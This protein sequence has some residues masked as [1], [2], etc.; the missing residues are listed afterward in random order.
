MAISGKQFIRVIATALGIMCM[1][2][3]LIAIG[4][5]SWL[6]MGP[7]KLS[8]LTPYLERSTTTD[9][10]QVAIGE[11]WIAWQGFDSPLLVKLDDVNVNA[12][13]QQHTLALAELNVSFSWWDIV[14][15]KITPSTLYLEDMSLALVMQPDGQITLA[16]AETHETSALPVP[17]Q[18]ATTSDDSAET[19]LVAGAFPEYLRSIIIEGATIIV[20]KSD[21]TPLAKLTQARLEII[22][23][24][25]ILAAFTGQLMQ[26]QSRA[27]VK[28]RVRYIP[29]LQQIEGEVTFKSLTQAHLLPFM[30]DNIR[31][32]LHIASAMHGW[33]NFRMEKNIL[34]SAQLKGEFGEGSWRLPFLENASYVNQFRFDA[35]YTTE[36]IVVERFSAMLNDVTHV[37]GKLRYDLPTEKSAP[38]LAVDAY[39][40]V[41]PVNTAKY[42]WPVG[43]AK[44]SRQWLVENVSGGVIR[45]ARVAVD[46]PSDIWTEAVLPAKAVAVQLDFE[47]SSVRYME[48]HPSVIQAR[49][50]MITDA[51]NLVVAIESARYESGTRLADGKVKILGL[52]E[53]NPRIEIGF[54]AKAPVQD[55]IAFL[56]KPPADYAKALALNADKA[57]G[58][59]TGAVD[60]GFYYDIPRDAHGKPIIDLSINSTVADL[61]HPSFMQKFDIENATGA[62][63]IEKDA[64]LFKGRGYVNKASLSALSVRHDF[65]GDAT[66]D[67]QLDITGKAPV[68]TLASL[69]YQTDG[70]IKGTVGLDIRIKQNTTS[71]H[72][73]GAIDLTAA[74]VA[75]RELDWHKPVNTPAHVTFDSVNQ[76]ERLTFKALTLTSENVDIKG[77]AELADDYSH[78]YQADFS[79]FTIGKQQLNTFAYSQ[80]EGGERFTLRG[81]QFYLPGSEG[82]GKEEAFSLKD[83]QHIQADIDV[84]TFGIAKDEVIH[85]LSAQIDC[86]EWCSALTARG[87]L[88]DDA[89]FTSSLAELPTGDR[90]WNVYATNAGSFL[91]FL[92]IKQNLHKGELLLSGIFDKNLPGHPLSGTLRI[93]Q[94]SV[95]KAPILAKL[96]TLASLSG[97]VNTL[98]GKGI[99]FDNFYADFTLKDTEIAVSNAKMIGDSIGITAE[100][101]IDLDKEILNLHGAVIPSYAINNIPSSIPLIGDLLTDEK[102]EGVFAANYSVSGTFEDPDI[103]VNPLSML[104]PGFLRG[105]FDVFESSEPEVSSESKKGSGTMEA[106]E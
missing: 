46:I 85:N 95:K 12:V 99:S 100:G 98:Q 51:K 65:S 66:Y 9:Q 10:I 1:G 52:M 79:P 45:K 47:D 13:G 19:L 41:I 81:K 27:P 96:L 62:L 67:T 38:A 80:M 103:M 29:D 104:T 83:L 60:I 93:K 21:Q 24:E 61:S 50:N 57:K 74:D 23:E 88:A 70:R 6:S 101:A 15:G 90:K 69:G 91:R 64:L 4:L 68:S 63:V 54:N 35:N 42:L 106:V 40:D 7:H 82:E 2:V 8:Q 28:G 33:G 59:F 87:V 75:L 89:T 49:G 102:D 14:Q 76:G 43:A 56:D 30:P 72:I 86:A 73:E 17:K 32:G 78:I 58:I 84:E 97:I 55:V 25:H 44:Q 5:F 77:R 22:K 48:D 3:V 71:E 105:I 34:V 18:F 20:K 39:V 11:T 26:K 53:D 94:F 92:G 36:R 31:D 16:P 37:N